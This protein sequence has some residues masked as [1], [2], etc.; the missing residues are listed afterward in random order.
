MLFCALYQEGSS[1]AGNFHF[2][3]VTAMNGFKPHIITCML[4]DKRGFLWYGTVH[5]L[6]RYNGYEIEQYINKL[7]DTNSISGNHILGL[8]EDKK[9]RIWVSTALDGLNC[10]DP[11]KKKFKRYQQN[12]GRKN[13]IKSDKLMRLYIDRSNRLWIGYVNDGWS[14]YNLDNG[15]INNYKVKTVFIGPY[16]N[17]HQIH[18]IVFRRIEMVVC[19]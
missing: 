9:G 19:G 17:D 1:F 2:V 10:F 13:A 18:L 8:A 3:N 15:Q 7:N 12:E 6:N 4:Q 11:I 14:V 5:G 16:G